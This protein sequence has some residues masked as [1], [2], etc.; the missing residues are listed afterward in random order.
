MIF[1]ILFILIFLWA[2]YKG[3]TK[4]FI[5]QAATLAALILGIWGSIKFS[6]YVAVVIMEKMEYH[7]EFVPLI[8]FALQGMLHFRMELEPVK[9]FLGI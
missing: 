2:A 4:G 7:G 1:D 5:L 9:P 6:G 3:F 8:S